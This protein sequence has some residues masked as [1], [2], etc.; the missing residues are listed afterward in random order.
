M[1]YYDII[2]TLKDG[3]DPVKLGCR[4]STLKAAKHHCEMLQA[5]CAQY[6]YK[7]VKL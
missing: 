5:R 7:V 2:S 3:T 6:N 1:K 4:Y